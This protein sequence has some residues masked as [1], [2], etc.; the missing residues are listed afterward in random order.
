MQTMQAVQVQR[1][2]DDLGGVALAEL[3]MP[4][5]AQ[6]EVLVRIEAAALGFPDLLMTRGGYQ[7]KPP[8]PFVPGMEG[9]GTVIEAR[10]CNRLREGD[11]VIVGGLTGAVAQYG[12]FPEGAVVPLPA[13][14]DMAEGAA[15][16][17]A[18]LTAWVALVRRGQAVAGEWL[19]VHG[20]AGGVG[21]AAVDLGNAL[22]LKVIAVASTQRKRDAIANLY[23]PDH[24]IDGGSGFYEQVLAITEGRGTDLVY[25][26]VGGDVFDESTRC[27]AFNGRLLVIGFAA[28]RIP[29][30]GANIALIKGFSVVGV[31]AG[32]YGRRFP[33]RG[34]ENVESI[35]KLAGE[36]RIR[37]NVH[38]RYAMSEWA[39][40]YRA[41]ERR[42]VIGRSVIL[43]HEG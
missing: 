8:L 11:R 1:L 39:S 9:A 38:A 28:G 14:L 41:M 7:A 29:Q 42:D 5:P 20:A 26:P 22:G 6:G 17:A 40:A 32:E 21:L 43:P 2:S 37:P 36:G 31:R 24:V 23:A 16:R 15:L 34:A 3:P 33:E 12:A 35:L 19:L 10:G 27:I 18:Y 4:V 25:D 13:R 30:I